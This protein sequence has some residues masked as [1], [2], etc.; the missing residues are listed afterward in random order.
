[1]GLAPYSTEREVEKSWDIFKHLFKIENNLIVPDEVTRDLFFHFKDA[2]LGHRFDGI[3]GAVQRMVELTNKVWFE[4]VSKSLGTTHFA[5][6]G[7]VAMNVKLNGVLAAEPYVDTIHVPPSGGDESLSLGAAY[8]ILETAFVEQ[9]RDVDAIPYIES[10][11][12]GPE[13]SAESELKTCTEAQQSGEFSVMENITPEQ[14]AQF[15]ADGKIISRCSGRMEFGQR[16]LGNRSIFADPRSTDVV[17]QIN[18]RIKYRDFWMPF[19]PVV[20]DEDIDNYFKIPADTDMRYMMSGL[21]T[22]PL[23]YESIP[24]GLHQGDRTGRPQLMK[25]SLNPEVY[26]MLRAFKEITGVGG[27]INTSFNIHGEPIVCTSD[28]ALKTM[29]NCDLDGVWINN[30]VIYRSSTFS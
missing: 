10:I 21:H 11:Y 4:S 19:A 22:T 2:L 27:T 28:D 1:M 24:G 18:T 16:S 3:A 7:G 30:R 23:G 6:S 5:Y 17:D 15:L 20:L 9:G 8:E 13:I 14:V 29:Q 25:E 26:S 12:L